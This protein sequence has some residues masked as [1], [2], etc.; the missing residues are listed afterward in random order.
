MK[1]TTFRVEYGWEMR[2]PWRTATSILVS[3]TSSW[4][5]KVLSNA[6][7][8]YS[9][10]FQSILKSST[11]RFFKSRQMA[12]PPPPAFEHRPTQFPRDHQQSLFIQMWVGAATYSDQ[13]FRRL[14][15]DAN[16]STPQITWR[17]VRRSENLHW[18]II[19]FF[20]KTKTSSFFLVTQQREK[21]LW[22]SKRK[23]TFQ[24]DLVDEHESYIYQ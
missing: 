13:H 11:S 20:R 12:S 16:P 14:Q 23:K 9:N 8:F 5:S 24:S 15:R 22:H 19:D 10:F 2:K 6:K 1:W 18:W 4:Y 21:V 17:S 7:L 3:L